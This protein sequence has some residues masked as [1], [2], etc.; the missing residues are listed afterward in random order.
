M[1]WMEEMNEHIK[2]A[3]MPQLELIETKPSLYRI[4]VDY[5]SG[6]RKGRCI[7]TEHIPH[8]KIDSAIR[9]RITPD[10]IANAKI[11]ILSSGLVID[12]DDWEAIRKEMMH[13]TSS[14]DNQS[15]IDAHDMAKRLPP[16]L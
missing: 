6:D 8:D 7:V 13:R 1:N 3:I 2:A 4:V 16:P 14:Q 10:M 5:I 11:V 12:L 15:G 9:E